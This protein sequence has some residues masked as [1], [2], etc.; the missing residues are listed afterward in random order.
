MF[1]KL[2]DLLQQLH[3]LLELK[4]SRC[5][6]TLEVLLALDYILNFKQNFWSQIVCF[7]FVEPEFSVLREFLVLD[8]FNFDLGAQDVPVVRSVY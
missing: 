1:D 4:L 7:S 5:D 3:V 8:L 2:S 6:F